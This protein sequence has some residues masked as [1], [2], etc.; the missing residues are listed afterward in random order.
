M[1]LKGLSEKELIQALRQEFRSDRENIILGI[2][3]DAAVIRPGGKYQVLTKDLLIENTHFLAA[4]HPADLLARKSLSVNLS[5]VAAM[6]CR[7]R[8]VLFG[9]GLPSGTDPVWIEEFMS[10]LKIAADEFDVSLVGGD[11]TQAERISISVTL[12]GEGDRFITRSGAQVGDRL[13]VSGT[14][15]DAAYGLDLLRDHVKLGDGSQT[16]ICLRAFLDPIPQVALGLALAQLAIPS[17]MIDVSD[18]LSV[19]LRHICEE[20]GIGAEVYEDTLP[21]SEALMSLSPDPMRMALHG[22]ED[23]HLLFAVSEENAPLI[24]KIQQSFGVKEIGR[25]I[26]GKEIYWINAAGLR[27]ILVPAGFQHFRKGKA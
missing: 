7:P 2:G 22:G 15:G 17:A 8:Y 6:G 27:E 23:Y 14:L 5:D 4:L 10:G 21:L 13:Y 9:L 3:D 18:G 1:K 26:P 24:S 16:D 19:D 11:V 12:L 25:F 20:S